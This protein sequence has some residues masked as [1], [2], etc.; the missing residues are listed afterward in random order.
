MKTHSIFQHTASFY[1]G[2]LVHRRRSPERGR[3]HTEGEPMQS[4][5]IYREPVFKETKIEKL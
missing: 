5:S 4:E 3:R 2:R 1:E